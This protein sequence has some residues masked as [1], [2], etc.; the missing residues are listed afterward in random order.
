MTAVQDRI[1]QWLR[2]QEP[3]GRKSDGSRYYQCPFCRGYR[4]LE[5]HISKPL[6]HCHKCGRGGNFDSAPRAAKPLVGIEESE[7]VDLLEQ[8]APLQEADTLCWNY[9]EKKRSLSNERINDL[10][11]HRGPSPARVYFPLYE[12]GGSLPVSFVGRAIVSC[13]ERYVLPG[14]NTI[15]KSLLLWG[16]HRI[17]RQL[18]RILVCEGALSAVH[19]EGAV[20]ILGKTISDA[21]IGI[22]RQVCREEVVVCLDGEA[23]RDAL[24][25][26]VRIARKTSLRVSVIHLPKGKDPD[27]IRNLEPYMKRRERVV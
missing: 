7:E 18:D 26:A 4:K 17:T 2:T 21:Q 27:D 25:V 10:R 14:C 5:V 16:T 6:W 19:H 20:A 23:G 22:L 9:L 24:R 13:F 3:Q 8:Y 15:R 1:T 11:P 12:L